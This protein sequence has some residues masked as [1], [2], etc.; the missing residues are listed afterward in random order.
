MPGPAPRALDGPEPP[1]WPASA[2]GPV[3]R[4]R[5]LD[6]ELPARGDRVERRPHPFGQ[7]GQVGGAERGR[8]LVARAANGHAELVGL[9]LQQQ[10]HRRRAAVDAQLGDASMPD[11]ARIASTTSRVW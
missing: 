3:A 4:G 1:A 2:A 6:V 7:P 5:H 10:V 9:E 8:L 11:A